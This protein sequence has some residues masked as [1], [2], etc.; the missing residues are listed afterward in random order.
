MATTHSRGSWHRCTMPCSTIVHWPATTALIDAACG[1]TS[2]VLLIGEGPPDDI[3]VLTAGLYIRGQRH[4]DLEREYL[5]VYHPNDER[6]PRLR[7]LPDSHLVHVTDLYT[8]EEL[9]TSPT[10]NEILPRAQIPEW[11]E[12]APGRAGS[13]PYQLGPRR[14]RGLGWLGVFRDRNDPE[15]AAPYPAICP[16]PANTGPRPDAGHDRDHPARQPPDRR[17][18][19]GPAWAD[20][21]GQ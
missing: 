4:E 8:A 16:R 2:N 5:E 20:H 6:V 11:L 7:Q 12:R 18:P 15:T 19:P 1:S 17:S 13:L 10:Y 21:R 9:K 3:R 14:S